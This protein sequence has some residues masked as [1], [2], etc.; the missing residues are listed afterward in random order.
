M[1]LLSEVRREHVTTTW[2]QGKIE[3]DRF[4]AE[5]YSLLC[6]SRHFPGLLGWMI[7]VEGPKK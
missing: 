6:A 5:Y 7:R 1:S 4:T 3:R 2:R